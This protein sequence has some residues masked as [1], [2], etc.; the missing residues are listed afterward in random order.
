MSDIHYGGGGAYFTNDDIIKAKKR[1]EIFDT[2]YI[3]KIFKDTLNL[4]VT[5]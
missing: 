5:S 1:Y 3:A 2:S 4:D